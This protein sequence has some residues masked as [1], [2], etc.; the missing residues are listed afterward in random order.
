MLQN[1]KF[2]V[3]NLLGVVLFNQQ[4]KTQR[5]QF[6]MRSS[7]WKI[8][9]QQIF[10]NVVDIELLLMN[11]RSPADMCWTYKKYDFYMKI[12]FKTPTPSTSLKKNPDSWIIMIIYNNKPYRPY[13][14]LF[15]FFIQSTLN[16]L[17]FGCFSLVTLSIN[18]NIVTNKI[19]LQ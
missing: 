4:S 17:L 6:A 16:I 10:G 18:Y 12:L 15:S 19:Y 5:S 2:I 9:E 11:S 14:V 13:I 8:W 1:K 3:D 7:H